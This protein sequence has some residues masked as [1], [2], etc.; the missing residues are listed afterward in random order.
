MQ[1]S[2]L[3]SFFIF[4]KNPKNSVINPSQKISTKLNLLQQILFF[5]KILSFSSVAGWVLGILGTTLVRFLTGYSA[6]ENNIIFESVVDFNLFT[7]FFFI[8]V[9]GPLFEELSFRLFFSNK[10]PIFFTGLIFF[11]FFLTNLILE[12]TVRNFNLDLEKNI[13]ILQLFLASVIFVIILVSVSN[14][15]I[16]QNQ[17]K[18]FLEKNFN[19][20][21]YTISIVFTLIHITNYL[22]LNQVFL[23]LP[24]LILP[25]LLLSFVFGFLRLE[26]NFLTAVL[27]H[28]V[29]NF[30]LGGSVFLLLLFLDVDSLRKLIE[31]LNSGQLLVL[32]E[33]LEASKSLAL[34]LSFSL[35]IFMYFLVFAIFIWTIFEFL[36]SKIESRY[37]D[38]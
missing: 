1:K 24:L 7:I 25:Q 15:I 8:V 12:F 9:L 13:W 6:T 23:L 5:I 38:S 11:W 32:I 18:D 35:L 27:A 2:T 30:F 34:S 17:L 33:N 37:P 29:Y 19:W 10:K 31:G 16:S 26:F 20:F 36:Q 14:L 3:R 22:N 28:S 21:F 4:L